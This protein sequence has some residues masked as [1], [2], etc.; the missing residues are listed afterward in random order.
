MDV[1]RS[2]PMYFTNCPYDLWI[3]IVRATFV[4]KN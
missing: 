3:A 2:K 4:K 1:L